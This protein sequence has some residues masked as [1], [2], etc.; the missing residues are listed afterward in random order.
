MSQSESQ[1]I[2]QGGAPLEIHY[3]DGTTE[4]VNVRLLKIREFPDYLRL[5]DNEPELADFLCS[6]EAG[7]SENLTTGSLLDI[8]DKGHELNFENACRWG[9][10][11]ANLN[12]ALLPIALRG[13]QMQSAFPNSAPTAPASSDAAQ[14]K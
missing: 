7:W 10:R 3:T 14:P 13:Q 11:R 5:V 6:R 12:E 1:A 4:T 2:I 8:C 9:Q